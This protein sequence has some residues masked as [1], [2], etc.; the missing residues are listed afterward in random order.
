MSEQKLSKQSEE[1]MLI[2]QKLSPEELIGLAKFLNV[3]IG[4]LDCTD[5]EGNPV[6]LEEA[7][8]SPKDYKF[9]P[10]YKE[11]YELLTDITVAFEM[12]ARGERR[13]LL[14]TLRKLQKRKEDIDGTQTED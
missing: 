12:K 7:M 11:L 2:F 3:N 10:K 14:R 9:D 1:L 4:R 13:A 6:E 5:Q 8:K